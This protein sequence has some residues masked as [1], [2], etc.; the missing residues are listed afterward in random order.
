MSDFLGF[1]E[2]ALGVGSLHPDAPLWNPHPNHGSEAVIRISGNLTEKQ[3]LRQKSV[4]MRNTITRRFLN[5]GHALTLTLTNAEDSMR[6]G[7]KYQWIRRRR[8]FSR[9]STNPPSLMKDRVSVRCFSFSSP[10][11]KPANLSLYPQGGSRQVSACALIILCLHCARFHD[12][13]VF[14]KIIIVILLKQ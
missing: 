1:R 6:C 11:L 4:Y 5:V 9:Q 10:S 2:T 3:E 13:F 12:D 14:M 7:P 8:L